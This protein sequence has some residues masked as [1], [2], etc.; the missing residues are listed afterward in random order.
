MYS[1]EGLLLELLDVQ[2][3]KSPLGNFQFTNLIFLAPQYHFGWAIANN[4]T[5]I[6]AGYHDP[7]GGSMGSG[8][9]NGNMQRKSFGSNQIEKKNIL[10]T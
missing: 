5:L 8:I 1:K 7:S 9:Y 2:K 4:V 10:L 3:C 6:S